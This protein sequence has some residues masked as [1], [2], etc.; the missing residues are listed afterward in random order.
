VSLIAVSLGAATGEQSDAVSTPT[1]PGQRVR[2]FG[3]T[4]VVMETLFLGQ[5]YVLPPISTG[6]YSTMMEACKT[7]SPGFISVK[8]TTR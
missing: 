8:I 6:S 7:G 4:A 3:D 2:N 1:P 5:I